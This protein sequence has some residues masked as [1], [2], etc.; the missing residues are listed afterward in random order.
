MLF[1]LAVVLLV[2]MVG[3]GL[4]LI[5]MMTIQQRREWQNR[6]IN[7]RLKVLIA[8]YKAL[9]GSFTGTLTVSP[10]HRRDLK[11]PAADVEGEERA[12]DERP[13]AER[14]RRIRDPV[15]AVLSDIV[16]FGTEEQV[17]LAATAMRDM[18]AGRPIDVG[19]IVVSLRDHI[20][21]VLD[22]APIPAGITIPA[23]GPARPSTGGGRTG[24]REGGR[25][26]GGGGGL[27]AGQGPSTLVETGGEGTRSYWNGWAGGTCGDRYARNSRRSANS[28]MALLAINL[29]GWCDARLPSVQE[30][31]AHCFGRG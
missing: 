17:A 30:K 5:M 13:G 10:A 7:E 4:R 1:S 24:Q 16:L 8:A 2:T 6:Q 25:G 11:R 28:K 20:R 22:L 27:G 19:P 31:T 3:M 26:G 14:A 18:A 21:A 23:Q 29:A 15:E 12:A 9:G